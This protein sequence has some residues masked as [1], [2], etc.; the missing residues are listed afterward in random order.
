[1]GTALRTLRLDPRSGAVQESAD[2]GVGLDGGLTADGDAVWVRSAER[3]LVRL[4]A[5][6]G[7]P[8]SGVSADVESAGDVVV[9]FGSV[10]TTAY[11]DAAV[12]R[13]PAG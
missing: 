13:L 11:D 5:A 8:V 9:A 12:F 7:A 1:M 4:D 6:T 10:W 2:I 3:F